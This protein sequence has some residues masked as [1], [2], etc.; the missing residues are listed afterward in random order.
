MN[1]YLPN[2]AHATFSTHPSLLRKVK[3]LRTDNEA[4]INSP[5]T[6]RTSTMIDHGHGHQYDEEVLHM[7]NLET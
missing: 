7:V 3:C 1:N 2:T 6:G 4:A 5:H